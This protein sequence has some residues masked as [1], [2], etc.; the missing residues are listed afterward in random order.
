M[1]LVKL[2]YKVVCTGMTVFFSQNG[3]HLT[4]R[5]SEACPCPVQNNSVMRCFLVKVTG[6]NNL[7]NNLYTSTVQRNVLGNVLE[8]W[9]IVETEICNLRESKYN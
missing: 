8:L 5:C 3:V 4:L 7:Y 6:I 2:I 9:V 1:T